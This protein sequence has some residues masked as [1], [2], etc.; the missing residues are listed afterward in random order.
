MDRLDYEQMINQQISKVIEE[1]TSNQAVLKETVVLDYLRLVKA[2]LLEIGSFNPEAIYEGLL[3]DYLNEINLVNQLVPGISTAIKDNKSGIELYTYSGNVSRKGPKLDENVQFD[4]ASITKLFMAIEAL[5]LAED[6]KFMLG[7]DVSS[8]A[9]GKY[10]YLQIPVIDMVR[11]YYSLR[12]DGRID[13]AGL[14][15]EEIEKRLRNTKVMKS[16]T[17]EY[18]DIPFIVLK[19]IMPDAD[20]YFKK[21]FYDIMGLYQTS[22][23]PLGIVTGG[24]EDNLCL[25]HDPKAYNLRR[26]NIN[27]GHAGIYSTSHDLVKLFDGL[28]AGF[29][30]SDSLDK[31]ITPALSEP[32]LLEDGHVVYKKNG[33]I[34]NIN[35]GLAAYIQHPDGFSATEVSPI[36]SA[37]AFSIV[38]F[39]GGYATFDLKNE[40][41]AN[42]LTNPLSNQAERILDLDSSLAKSMKVTGSKI[43]IAGNKV[44]VMS[45]NDSIDVPYYKIIQGLKEK[46]IDVI[47]ALRLAKKVLEART[48]EEE[49]SS[50]DVTRIFDTVKVLRR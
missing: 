22:Y 12:T 50:L 2:K 43:D 27:P 47:L 46:Q 29:L 8:Y 14:T 49:D 35:R 40:V 31:L 36:L 28:K 34:Q 21:Y 41:T 32:Y 38:G 16:K 39:T 13:D 6:G 10:K 20:N 18:S 25:V 3:E 11:F 42:I 9:G 1:L 17:F 45:D 24:N 4:V 37:K 5:K 23:E 33:K 15:L 7:K 44:H 48:L 30:S 19:D 26:F